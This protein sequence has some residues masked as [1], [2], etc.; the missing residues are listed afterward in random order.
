M[1]KKPIIGISSSIII[2]QGGMF[3]GYKRTYVNKDYVDAVIKN[4]G[5]PIII[6][7]N[8]DREITKQL[9]NHIDALILSGGHDVAPFNYGEEPQQ[10]LGEIFPERDK[11]DY[12]LLSEG[13]KKG[14]PILGICRGLQVIN[15]Y[16]GGTL[17]QDLSYIDTVPVY[18]HS[19]GHSPELK[20]HS[21]KISENS[22]LYEIFGTHEIRVN[23]F[24]HQTLKKVAENY[25]VTA[26]AKD[27]VIEAIE[28]KNYPF[29]VGVQWHPEMLFKV[30][31]D[32][33]RLF[34]VFIN[35]AKEGKV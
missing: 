34:S 29:L 11:F 35:K 24:H 33:N 32:M 1:E 14:I 10:K 18:K 25:N 28:C 7:F 27:G 9:V 26:Q 8:E 3:P 19:Q 22:H 13:K 16:E 17:H 20:T 2:D 6:P 5:L 15:T 4:G 23:S 21:V 30:H 12:L 31:D